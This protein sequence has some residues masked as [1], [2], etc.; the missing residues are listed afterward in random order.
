MRIDRSKVK[1]CY[2]QG[3]S[4]RQIA[5]QVGGTEGRVQKIIWEMKERGEIP[6]DTPIDEGRVK[7]LR[8]AGWDDEMISRDMHRTVEEIKS[9]EGCDY[10]ALHW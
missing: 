4:N 1:E 9:V 10:D 5:K 2:M 7:A 3:M 8:H 6:K